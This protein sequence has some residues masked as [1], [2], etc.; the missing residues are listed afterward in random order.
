MTKTTVA[1]VVVV[2]VED[3]LHVVYI[4]KANTICAVNL[5]YMFNH[6]LYYPEILQVRLLLS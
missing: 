2:V 5:K 4:E 1:V 3:R 6:L